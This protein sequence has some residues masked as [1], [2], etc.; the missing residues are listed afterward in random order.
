MGALQTD[1]LVV[2]HKSA[3]LVGWL[4]KLNQFMVLFVWLFRL[5]SEKEQII[6]H[7]VAKELSNF[8]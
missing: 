7:G 5:F 3:S 8:I 2:F 1:L 4:L 6:Y